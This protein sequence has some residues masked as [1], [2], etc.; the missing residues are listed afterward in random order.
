MPIPTKI[1]GFEMRSP[2][3]GELQYFAKNPH[4]AGMAT[5]D[6]RII[7]NPAS[8][9]SEQEKMA[10]AQNEALRLFMKQKNFK[11]EFDLTD[12]QM[13]FFQGLKADYA[14]PENKLAAQHTIISRIMSGD[15]SAGTPSPEQ[16]KAVKQLKAMLPK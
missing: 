3:A 10:V 6:N 1:H 12:E 9:L 16:M 7:L 13:K 11:P 5:E 14:K 4:V 2:Y 8:G 15:P